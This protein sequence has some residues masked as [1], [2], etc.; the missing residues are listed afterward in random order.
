MFPEEIETRGG[1]RR[2]RTLLGVADRASART[3][4]I[5]IRAFAATAVRP[6]EEARLPLQ[7]PGFP[8]GVHRFIVVM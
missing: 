6:E 3:A 4:A 7:R 1:R 2:R 8:M 5:I